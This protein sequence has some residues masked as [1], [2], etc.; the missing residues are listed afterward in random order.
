MVVLGTDTPELTAADLEAA[1]AGLEDA[2]VVLGP[3]TDGGYWL[4][5]LKRPFAELF[6]NIPWGGPGVLTATEAAGAAAGLRIR[7]LRWLSDIDTAADWE[8]WQQ[9][10][11]LRV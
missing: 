8:A 3:A 5:G 10:L 11:G 4:I 9:R 6:T 7:R 2:D 1:F